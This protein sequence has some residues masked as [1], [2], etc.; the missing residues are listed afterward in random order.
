M[1][2]QNH[3]LNERHLLE[4]SNQVNRI[5]TTLA[6][7]S[8]D[9]R[10]STTAAERGLFVQVGEVSPDT[11]RAVI[12]ARRLRTSFFDEELFADPAWDMML[13]LFQEEL[14]HRRV[15]V[16]SLCA[17]SGVPPTTA[18]R[19]LKTMVEKGLFLR[20]ADPLDGRRIYVELAP[21]TREALTRYFVEIGAAQSI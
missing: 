20:R 8:T 21:H 19:W 18:L 6:R 2:A 14:A 5:A 9:P 7:L 10:D 15:S 3:Q 17:A 11:V 16:S 4:L 12:R 1:S 13:D